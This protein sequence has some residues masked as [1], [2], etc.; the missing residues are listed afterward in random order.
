M[1]SVNDLSSVG[2]VGMFDITV[3][4]S[5]E[6]SYLNALVMLTGRAGVCTSVMG[7]LYRGSPLAFPVYEMYRRSITFVTGWA[8][9]SAIMSE[10]IDLIRRGV[11]DPMPVTTSI[12]RWDDAADALV[13]PFTKSIISRL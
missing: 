5:G 13:Q 3:D 1:T 9:T 6:A 7:M 2:N 10:P 11:F 8:H 4:A 12:V